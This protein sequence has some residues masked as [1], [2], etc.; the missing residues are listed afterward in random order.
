MAIE[1]SRVAATPVAA[2]PIADPAPLGLAAFALTTFVLSAHNASAFGFGTHGPTIVVGLALFYGGLAQFMAGMWSFRRGNTFTAT[3]FSTYGAFWL[4]VGTYLALVTFGKVAVADI[5]VSLGW[6]F[7]GFL[8]FNTYMMFWALRVNLAVFLVFLT[9]GLTELVL[10]WGNFAG[11]MDIVHWG[12]WL[13]TITALV[14]WYTSA[15]DVITGIRARPHLPV[16]SPLWA[17]PAGM[18]AAT[19]ASTVRR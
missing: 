16:G 19:P 13:G 3:A 4:A 9:L 12:G 17:E 15:A 5:T 14:D 2:S 7:L 6:F 11:N 10:M 18:T 1:S 8:I